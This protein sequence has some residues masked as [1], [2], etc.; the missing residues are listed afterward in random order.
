M[1][2]EV[3]ELVRLGPLPDEGADPDRVMLYQGILE[4]IT[5]PVSNEEA[6]ALVKLFGTDECYG[7][8]WTL[9]HLIETAPGWPL[10][11]SFQNNNNE[12]VRRLQ[13]RVENARTFSG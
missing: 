10:E 13:Q 3:Y 6:E 8:A 12:W 9:L 11:R 1:R 2:Q 5:S 7:L 4:K